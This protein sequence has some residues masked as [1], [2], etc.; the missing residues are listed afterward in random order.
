[1][2]NTL[3]RGKTTPHSGLSQLL[4]DLRHSR[5][6]TLRECSKLVGVSAV[7][8]HHWE[9]GT[10]VPSLFNLNRYLF[11]LGATNAA[12]NR[13]IRALHGLDPLAWQETPPDLI[14]VAPY[15]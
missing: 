15:P 9:V 7:A 5:D 1:M 6:L 12:R 8:L 14:V 13:V 2:K 3:K 10:R 11:A 4:K